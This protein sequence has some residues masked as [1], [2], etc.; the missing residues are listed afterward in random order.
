MGLQL[1][2]G[3]VDNYA[4]VFVVIRI[5]S[6]FCKLLNFRKAQKALIRRRRE[7]GESKNYSAM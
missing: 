4:H 7:K 1:F 5:P 6:V 3:V 2:V